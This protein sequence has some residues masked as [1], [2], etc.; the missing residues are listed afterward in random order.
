MWKYWIIIILVTTCCYCHRFP[1]CTIAAPF[2]VKTFADASDPYC[3][4]IQMICLICFPLFYSHFVLCAKDLK[5][6][7]RIHVCAQ[8]EGL[9][10]EKRKRND[11]RF[12][13]RNKFPYVLRFHFDCVFLHILSDMQSTNKLIVCSHFRDSPQSVWIMGVL[14]KL[15]SSKRKQS[16]KRAK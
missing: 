2:A 6:T 8:R 16:S 3:V 1:Q 14:I 7:A 11:V 9:E 10:Y 15:L 4:R 5:H 13:H 12:P